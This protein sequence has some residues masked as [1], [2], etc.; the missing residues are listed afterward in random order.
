VAGIVSLS[1][2][3]T[4]RL[5]REAGNVAHVTTDVGFSLAAEWLGGPARRIEV[6]VLGGE[7]RD[8]TDDCRDNVI[9]PEVV[10]RWSQ[11]NERSLVTFR[12]S[13]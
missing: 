2:S 12:L 8:V 10:R 3:G 11:Q 1:A 6:L 7:W 9:P 4:L 5:M 13:R